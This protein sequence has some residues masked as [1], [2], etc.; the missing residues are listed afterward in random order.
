MAFTNPSRVQS[1][2]IGVGAITGIVA[3]GM[4]MSMLDGMRAARA[5][6]EDDQAMA[7][8]DHALSSARHDARSMAALAKTAVTAALD[9]QH[10]AE[11]LRIEVAQLRRAV[12]QRD[13]AIRSLTQ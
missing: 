4:M 9:A 3:H 6:R 8:W 2:A 1:G 5:T 10:E 11:D 13:A 7:A 12:A